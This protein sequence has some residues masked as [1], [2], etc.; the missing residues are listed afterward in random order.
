MIL[1]EIQ[2]EGSRRSSRVYGSIRWIKF[3]KMN[4]SRKVRNDGLIR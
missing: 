1:G 3:S 4:G 2:D